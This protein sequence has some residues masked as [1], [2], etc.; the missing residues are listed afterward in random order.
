MMRPLKVSKRSP[1]LNRGGVCVAAMQLPCLLLF[2]LLVCACAAEPLARGNGLQLPLLFLLPSLVCARGTEPAVELLRREVHDHADTHVRGSNDELRPGLPLSQ[3]TSGVEEDDQDPDEERF[4]LE[5]GVR[6]PGR[7]HAQGANEARARRS[8]YDVEQESEEEDDDHESE[9]ELFFSAREVQR[10][11]RAF[12]DG[13]HGWRPGAFSGAGAKE[14]QAHKRRAR[15]LAHEGVEALGGAS[16]GISEEEYAK[17]LAARVAEAERQNLELRRAQA[18]KR[19]SVGNDAKQEKRASTGIPAASLAEEPNADER[20]MPRQIRMAMS[21]KETRCVTAKLDTNTVDF[22]PCAEVENQLWYFY[23]GNLKVQNSSLCLA[24]VVNGD[25]T[26]PK[27]RLIMTNCEDVPMQRW[28]IDTQPQ[29]RNEADHSMCGTVT[30]LQELHMR[31]CSKGDDQ[32]LHFYPPL[33][34]EWNTWDEWGS[35]PVTCG[36]GRVT[37]NRTVLYEA[38]PFGAACSGDS[39]QMGICEE[40]GCPVDCSFSNWRQWTECS[41][42][43]GGGF[44]ERRRVIAL[45]ASNGGAECT[46]GFRDNKSCGEAECP[47]DCIWDVWQEWESCPVTCGTGKKQRL[48]FVQ[49]MAQFGGKACEVGQKS[50]QLQGIS[51]VANGEKISAMMGFPSEWSKC[52]TGFTPLGIGHLELDGKGGFRTTTSRCSLK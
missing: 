14:A 19:W 7:S 1:R 49:V 24:E 13:N 8:Y 47:V 28:S 2:P 25:A 3:E 48:R 50:T 31:S 41:T 35:C 21:M 30:K 42:T 23:E 33:D 43:C 20:T 18:L 16:E 5:H 45:N 11:R 10:G 4:L 51:A 40:Q 26:K 22:E 9:E 37:R 27:G 6:R 32:K 46:G 36:G 29:L 15:A 44:R 39:F 12:S 38:E 52:P 34:C 17:E